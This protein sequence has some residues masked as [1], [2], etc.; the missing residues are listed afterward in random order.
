MHC[1]GVFLVMAAIGFFY[2]LPLFLSE[3]AATAG[4]GHSMVRA[5][6]FAF[7]IVTL[8][9]ASGRCGWLMHEGGQ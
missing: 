4:L 7:G 1:V 8:G 3:V 9:M 2:D 5:A 6:V